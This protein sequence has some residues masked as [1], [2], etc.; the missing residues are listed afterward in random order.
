MSHTRALIGADPECFVSNDGVISHC[1]DILGGSKDAPR[2]VSG[3]AVQEDNVLFEFNVDPTDNAGTF[4]D[5]IYRVMTQGS[6]I[7][8]MHNLE[9]VRNVSSHVYESLQGYPEKAFEF[10]C[11]PDY[12]ALTGA[13]NPRPSATN[14]LLRTAGGH[15]HIGWSHLHTVTEQDQRDVMVACDYVLGLISLLE[16]PDIRRRELY[17]KAGACR[18]KSYGAEYRTLSNYWIFNRAKTMIVHARAQEA[19]R[20]G[21]NKPLFETLKSVLPPEVVQDCINSGNVA[22]AKALIEV[23]SHATK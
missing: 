2:I 1:I 3:G 8:S 15:V 10:G 9:L 12:N 5:L 6:D 4:A 21:T 16:D 23:V 7:L 13:V 19:Y 14:E 17:G 18:L 22:E 20:I 11:T